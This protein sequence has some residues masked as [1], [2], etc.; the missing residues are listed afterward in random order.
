MGATRNRL[1]A[2]EQKGRRN[3]RNGRGQQQD[4]ASIVQHLRAHFAGVQGD[5]DQLAR[6]LDRRPYDPDR[7]VLRVKKP[8]DRVAHENPGRRVAQIERR[9]YRFRHR[10]G[11]HKLAHGIALQYDVHDAGVFQQFAFKVGVDHLVDVGQH[12]ERRDLPTLQPRLHIILAESRDR[13]DK[14]QDLCQHDKD[15]GQQQEPPGKRIQKHLRC[16]FLCCPCLCGHRSR[17]AQG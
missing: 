16:P 15:D 2:K 8:Q 9:R 17:A 11:Q 7:A 5:L 10:R 3:D 4:A 13:G 14:D 1:T 6:L 12:T